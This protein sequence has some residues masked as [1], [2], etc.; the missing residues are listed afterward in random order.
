MGSAVHAA[1]TLHTKAEKAYSSLS[2]LSGTLLEEIDSSA[3]TLAASPTRRMT[4]LEKGLGETHAAYLK[5]AQSALEQAQQEHRRAEEEI[6]A[7][8]SLFHHINHSLTS[9]IELRSQV[10]DNIRRM[11]DLIG[12]RRRVPDELWAMIFWE[13]VMEDEEEY[14][15]TWREEKPPFTTLKLT[16]VCCLWRRIITDRPALWQYIPLPH[17][18]LLSPTQAER[19]K[20]FLERLK[21]YT[22][23]VYMVCGNGGIQRDGVELRNLLAGFKRFLYFEAQVFRGSSALEELLET[24]QPE[25]EKLVLVSSPQGAANE[26]K[27]YLSYDAIKNVKSIYCYGVRP[28]VHRRS[29]EGKQAQLNSLLMQAYRVDNQELVTFLEASGTVDFTLVPNLKF[30]INREIGIQQDVALT[31]LTT[32]NA[33][34]RALKLVFN[35]HVLLPNLRRLTVQK[36]GDLDPGETIEL[37]TSFL[38]VHERRD[39]ITTLGIV[40]VTNQESSE[41][42]TAMFSDFIN[43]VS[44]GDRLILKEHAVVPSLKG[45]VDSKNI[46]P[47]IITVDICDCESVTEDLIMAFLNAY[48]TEERRPLSFRIFDC[49]SISEDAKQRLDLAHDGLKENKMKKENMAT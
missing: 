33:P 17:A 27:S 21:G 39:T 12:P 9:R 24:V 40:W 7:N 4:S 20:Y 32:V 19:S 41:E 29:F 18:L 36:D 26:V 47:N 8:G 14:E 23:S 28:R 37:W 15:N 6:D 45:L 11:K 34:L 1:K 22:P 10:N 31:Q 3:I 46:P 25:A 43:Q 44:S 49:A 38:S 48:Y 5:A 16:W 30:S 35:E 42:I 2:E 13:R